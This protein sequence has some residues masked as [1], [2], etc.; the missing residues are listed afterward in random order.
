MDPVDVL[1]KVKGV[2]EWCR[3]R[4]ETNGESIHSDTLEIT[5]WE[6]DGS[7]GNRGVARLCSRDVRMV[8][9]EAAATDDILDALVSEIVE[10]YEIYPTPGVAVETVLES[11]RRS[12]VKEKEAFVEAL[13]AI[14]KKLMVSHENF[15]VV[16][17]FVQSMELLDRP[18]LLAYV[19]DFVPEAS[20]RPLTA[21]DVY[22]PGYDSPRIT[23]LSAADAPE[24]EEF[25]ALRDSDDDDEDPE[26]AALIARAMVEIYGP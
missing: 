12:Y 17:Y 18:G 20:S 5:F 3:G 23:R 16:S 26:M 11:V 4:L 21:A 25:L 13:V 1:Y 9:N 10:K 2:R 14:V 8:D 7:L 24:M 6:T 19:P 15:G 22:E